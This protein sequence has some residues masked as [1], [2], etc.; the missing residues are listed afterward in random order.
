[1]KY[2]K[3]RASF[4]CLFY[5]SV[6]AGQL[7]FFGRRTVRGSPFYWTSVRNVKNAQGELRVSLV[8]ADLL[9][10]EW[11]LLRHPFSLGG[12]AQEN[13]QLASLVVTHKAARFARV[14]THMRRT[15]SSVYCPLYPSPSQSLVTAANVC[16]ISSHH[17]SVAA[18]CVCVTLHFSQRITLDIPTPI[19]QQSVGPVCVTLFF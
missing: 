14:N 15:P 18:V 9:H 4:R 10:Q 1:M 11:P 12:G 2:E 6:C 7:G 5:H 13:N 19:S 8:V 16:F 17:I 3:R